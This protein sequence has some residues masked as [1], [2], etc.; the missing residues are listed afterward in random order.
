MLS[1]DSNPKEAQRKAYRYLGKTAKL[2]PAKPPKKY[3]IFDP[4]HNKWVRFGQLGYQ[5]FTKH[6]DKQRRSNYLTRTAS[7]RGNWK[8]NPYSANNLSRHILW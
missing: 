5:D 1:D 3:K 7:M 4:V 6:R 2:Y 8:S